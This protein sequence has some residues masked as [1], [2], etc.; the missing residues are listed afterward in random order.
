MRDI[1]YHSLSPGRILSLCVLHEAFIYFI[2]L[3]IL[4]LGT[5]FRLYRYRHRAR[6][7]DHMLTAREQAKVSLIFLRSFVGISIT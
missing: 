3:S 4:S 6:R 1:I 5:G 2:Y 7:L